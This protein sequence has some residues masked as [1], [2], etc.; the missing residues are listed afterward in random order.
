MSVSPSPLGWLM[1][2]EAGDYPTFDVRA[3]ARYY[4]GTGFDPIPALAAAFVG[5]QRPA[6]TVHAA[7]QPFIDEVNRPSANRCWHGSNVDG[8]HPGDPFGT[9]TG[10]CGAHWTYYDGDGAYCKCCYASVYPGAD[11]HDIYALWEAPPLEWYA[12]RITELVAQ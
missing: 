1:D 12:Q 6:D 2:L 3:T 11:R 4:L 9:L 7:G 5:D 8:Y 10:C